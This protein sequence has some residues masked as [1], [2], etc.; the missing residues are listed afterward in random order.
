MCKT[1]SKP[2]NNFDCCT[3]R[4]HTARFFNPRFPSIPRTCSHY[5]CVHITYHHEIVAA[6]CRLPSMLPPHSSPRPP[7]SISIDD[8]TFSDRSNRCLQENSSQMKADKKTRKHTVCVVD[9]FC[10]LQVFTRP[11]CVVVFDC[12]PRPRGLATS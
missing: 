7:P 3:P 10:S 1:E 4:L 9:S 11:D 5:F 2:L 8:N 6:R 12:K